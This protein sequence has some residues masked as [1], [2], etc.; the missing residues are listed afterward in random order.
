M[1]LDMCVLYNETV[2]GNNVRNDVSMIINKHRSKYKIW[3][4]YTKSECQTLQSCS[5]EKREQVKYTN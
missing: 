1:C 3:E 4:E 5:K 2:L